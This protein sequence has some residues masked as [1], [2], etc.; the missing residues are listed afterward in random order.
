MHYNIKQASHNSER[1]LQ[2]QNVI[3]SH[4]LC[5]AVQQLFLN[6]HFSLCCPQ[7]SFKQQRPFRRREPPP[8]SQHRNFINNKLRFSSPR[9]AALWSHRLQWQHS[10]HRMMRGESL[11][12][13]PLPLLCDNCQEQTGEYQSTQPH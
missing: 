12:L 10:D 13:Q 6:Y 5:A 1:P 3:I 4:G 7:P 8:C 2:Q 11:S 9:E